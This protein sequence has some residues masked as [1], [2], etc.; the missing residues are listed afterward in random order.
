MND[1]TDTAQTER[2]KAGDDCPK[3]GGELVAARHRFDQSG[4]APDCDW[5]TCL[6]C[7]FATDP[8]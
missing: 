7:N 1:V 6:D 3:C 2:L 8:E 4:G 5:L